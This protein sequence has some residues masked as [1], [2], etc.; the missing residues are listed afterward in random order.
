MD[1]DIFTTIATAWAA[2]AD[3]FGEEQND[4]FIG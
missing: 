3:T 2:F 4:H 1:R